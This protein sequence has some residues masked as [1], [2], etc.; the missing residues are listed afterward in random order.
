MSIPSRYMRR[1]APR[2]LKRAARVHEAYLRIAG[3]E[4]DSKKP[5]DWDSRGHFFGAAAIAMRR[6]LVERARFQNRL[7]HGGGRARVGLDDALSV[8]EPEGAGRTDLI[9]L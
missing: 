3:G 2:R 8:A 1:P 5:R 4:D 9:A 6:I 7:K